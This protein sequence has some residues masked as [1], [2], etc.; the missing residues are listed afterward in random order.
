M[1]S[2]A[3]HMSKNDERKC[4]EHNDMAVSC[5]QI[6]I[7]HEIL[8]RLDKRTDCFDTKL[9]NAIQMANDGIVQN[10]KD[11]ALMQQQMKQLY[12][13]RPILFNMVSYKHRIIG[14]FGVIGVLLGI[15][16]FKIFTQGGT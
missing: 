2:G 12:D 10:A 9:D 15:Y 3:N 6:G 7:M 13:E 11:I 8:D 16:G 1:S 4:N 14:G 5:R